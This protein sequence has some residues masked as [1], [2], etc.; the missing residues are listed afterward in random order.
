MAVIYGDYVY[1]HCVRHIYAFDRDGLFQALKILDDFVCAKHRGYFVGYMTYEAGVLLQADS[2]PPYRHL[3]QRRRGAKQPLLYFALYMERKKLK[4]QKHKNTFPLGIA[5]GLEWDSYQKNFLAIKNNIKNGHT[6]QLNYT[7]EILLHSAFSPRHV[8][9][10][11]LSYQNTKYK[12]R[13]CNAFLQVLCF[14]P[15]LFFSIK[16]GVI[17]T[18]PM[19]GTIQRI[20]QNN[21]PSRFSTKA[22]DKALKRTLQK[23]SKNR[24]ENLMIVDLLRN[25][26]SKVIKP[27]S[28][29]VKELCAIHSYPSLHQMVSTIE[30]SVGDDFLLSDVLCALFPCGSITGAPKLKTMDIIAQLESRQ[31]GVYC[32]ALGMVSAKDISFCVPIRTLSKL[33]HEEVYRYGVGSGVVWDSVC[34]DEFAELELKSQFLHA[35]NECYDLFETMLCRD[36]RIFLLREHI[37]RLYKSALALGFELE[38]LKEILA[39]LCERECDMGMFKADDFNAF[40]SRYRGLQDC[41]SGLWEEASGL[42]EKLGVNLG[43]NDKACILRLLMRHNGALSLEALPLGLA[44]QPSVVLSLCALDSAHPLIRHK[45]TYRTHFEKARAMIEGGKIFDMIFYNHKGEIMEGSRCNIVCEIQGRFYTPHSQ[46]GLLQGT[47]RDM[48]LRHGLIEQKRLKLK[49]L[50]KAQ[51]IFCINSVRGIVEVRLVKGG[52]EL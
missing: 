42:C 16:K 43:A 9:N 25:D 15:E 18:Q 29:R 52:E 46:S 3:L 14:S 21:T 4:R 5:R 23:D 45:T 24:S 39:I 37:E 2:A 36:N 17:T 7:Q 40:Y 13:I 12:A 30:G 47:L 44:P 8:F 22:N 19:K 20:S 50:Q 28:L 1:K 6:Y 41:D 27:H 31:R 49:A 32:G 34:E 11:L 33:K 10:S 26:L 38:N 51:R 48:L 35:K